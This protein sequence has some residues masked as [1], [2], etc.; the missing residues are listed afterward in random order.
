VG[1]ACCMGLL[2]LPRLWPPGG[3]RGA[4]TSTADLDAY[5]NA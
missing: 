1:V 2:V 3:G 4:P 5:F